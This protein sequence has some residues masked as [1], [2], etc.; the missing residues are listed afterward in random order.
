[1][2]FTAQLLQIQLRQGEKCSFRS[3]EK[4]RPDQHHDLQQDSQQHVLGHKQSRVKDK[5]SKQGFH[6][7]LPARLSGFGQVCLQPF[8]PG[9]IDMTDS[10]SDQTGNQ[11]SR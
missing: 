7:P 2:L 10:H 5:P 4:G 3:R 6:M 8:L 9:F 11:K 1:M